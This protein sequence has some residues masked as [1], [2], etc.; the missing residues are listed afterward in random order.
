[1]RRKEV[2]YVRLLGF[3]ESKIN[4]IDDFAIIIIAFI[5]FEKWQEKKIRILQ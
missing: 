1:V 3:I 2:I 5:D 4:K